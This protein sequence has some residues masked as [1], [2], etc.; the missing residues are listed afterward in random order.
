MAGI[1]QLMFG[2]VFIP[3][4]FISRPSACGGL[5]FTEIAEEDELFTAKAPRTQ[6][7]NIFRK[8]AETPIFLN[9]PPAGPSAIL[10]TNNPFLPQTT[11]GQG[12]DDFVVT[13]TVRP[14]GH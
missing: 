4:S 2:D 5:E 3:F 6:R 11:A 1:C 12:D 13:L 9:P 14:S 7:R 8:I 10:F